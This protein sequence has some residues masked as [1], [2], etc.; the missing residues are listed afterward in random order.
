MDVTR[1]D[2]AIELMRELKFIDSN[3]LELKKEIQYKGCPLCEVD[4]GKIVTNHQTKQAL[5]YEFKKCNKCSLIYPYPRPNRNIIEGTCTDDRFSEVTK[6]KLKYTEQLKKI[7]SKASF[8]VRGMKRVWSNVS[9]HYSYQEFKKY[10]RKGYKVLN[11]GAGTGTMTQELLKKGCIVE[12]VELNPYRAKYLRENI[13][14]K[15]YEGTFESADLQQSSY[16]MVVL[17]QVLMHLFS[18]K[19]T[20]QKIKYVLRPG[21][22][23]V[24][25]QMNFNSIVQ[26]TVRAPCPGKMLTAFSICSWFTPES[27]KKVLEISGFK[28]I[29]IM[30]RP[31]GLINHIFVEGYPGGFFGK[32]ALKLI[33]QIIIFILMRTG[34]TDY[35]AIVAKKTD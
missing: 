23:I 5:F 3:T 21:G 33:D 29:E 9:F 24:S 20:F 17:S 34:T 31:T 22:I 25:S 30:Y 35:F 6:S 32:I 12:A 15:V 19:N 11:I 28:T 1:K 14:I 10:A 4:D 18:L 27:L 16:D 13:G 7:D 2:Q 26:Q 8:L